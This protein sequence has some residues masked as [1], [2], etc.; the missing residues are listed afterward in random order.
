MTSPFTTGICGFLPTVSTGERL[1]GW[2]EIC[3]MFEPSRTGSGC[4]L[5]YCLDQGVSKHQDQVGLAGAS[6]P[7]PVS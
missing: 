3:P 1:M 2:H 4:S 5:A 6:S 7:Q